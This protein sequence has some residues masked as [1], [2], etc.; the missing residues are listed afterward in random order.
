MDPNNHT[1]MRNPGKIFVGKFE[2][3]ET[4]GRPKRKWGIG[5]K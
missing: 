2:G 3:N 5:S 1:G 4:P